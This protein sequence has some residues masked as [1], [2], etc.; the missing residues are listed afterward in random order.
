[1]F[2]GWLGD[3]PNPLEIAG[4]IDDCKSQAAAEGISDPGSNLYIGGHS[5]GGIMLE[6]YI[7]DHPDLASGII[8]LGS[9]LPDLFGDV[10]NQFPVP[11]LTVVGELDGLTVSYVYR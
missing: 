7:N 6:T 1:M 9:Y 4:A 10:S 2:R 11:V 8:L 5:L 3:F